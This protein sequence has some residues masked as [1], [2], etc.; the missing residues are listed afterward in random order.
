[1]EQEYSYLCLG[2]FRSRSSR[3]GISGK[4][5]CRV[6]FRVDDSNSKFSVPSFVLGAILGPFCT[7]L[8]NPDRWSDRDEQGEIAYVGDSHSVSGCL[9]TRPGIDSDG[10]WNTNGESRL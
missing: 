10:D 9:L 4:L 2:F 7:N 1:M 8:I 3:N 5:V 6:P